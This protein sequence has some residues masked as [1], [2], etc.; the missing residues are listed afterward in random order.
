MSGQ[1]DW[2]SSSYVIDSDVL[3]D[4][5]R[6]YRT[7][8]DFIDTLILDG[9]EVCFSVIS[10]AEIYSN[11]Q[12]GEEASI[13]ALFRALTRLN[14]NGVIARKAGEYRALYRRS[15]GMALPDALIAATALVHQSTLITRNVRHYPM[16]DIQVVMPFEIK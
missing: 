13:L 14:V 9:A 15:H 1:G 3:I 12:P 4:H 16:L 11:V 8:L 7:A 5:L 6:G 2:E 10:E